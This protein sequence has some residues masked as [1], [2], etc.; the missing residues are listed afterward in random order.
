MK[1]WKKHE[2][3][4]KSSLITQRLFGIFRNLHHKISGS[5]PTTIFA[6][7]QTAKTFEDYRRE[8]DLEKSKAIAYF[9]ERQIRLV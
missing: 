5:K 3:E 1:S 8:F 2:T 4:E 7:Y 6:G 9:R